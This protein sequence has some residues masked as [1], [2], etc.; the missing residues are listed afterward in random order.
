MKRPPDAE[1]PLADRVRS[2]KERLGPL[3]RRGL[4]F[5]PGRGALLIVDMQR[6]F[7]DP[8]RRGF[9]PGG[10]PILPNVRRL[11]DS[12]RTHGLPV[13]Y[14]R[15]VHRDLE[16]DGGMMAAWWRD[17]I[18]EGTPDAEI[19]PDVAPLPGET[20]LSKCRYSAFHGTDLDGILRDIGVRDLVIAGV[21]TNLCCESTARDA[22][23]H[24]Y[25]VIFPLDATGAV[26]EEF[27][28]STLRNLA[29]GF[30]H[31]VET[32]EILARMERP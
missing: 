13:L 2:W 28:I 9:T 25:R 5:D 17:H 7:L 31:V 18:M 26:N 27:H 20:V 22:F 24:D 12:F 3:L 16:S 4:E 10:P 21:M 15:H 19:H 11:L 1:E 8:G 32:R 23:M 14:S 6:Y 30:A 29:Y